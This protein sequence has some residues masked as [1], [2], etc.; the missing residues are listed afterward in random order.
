MQRI[1]IPAMI[2]VGLVLVALGY[3][4]NRVLPARSYWSNEQAAEYTAAQSA[5]HSMAHNHGNVDEAHSQEFL[6]AKDRYT[7]ISGELESARNS[8]GRI[9]TILIAVGVISVLS[10]ATMHYRGQSDD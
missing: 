1:L 4:W 8:R 9:G 3:E 10:A 6:A 7:K 5:L 2:L